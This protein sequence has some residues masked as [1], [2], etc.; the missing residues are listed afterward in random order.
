MDATTLSTEHS[1]QSFEDA[2]NELETLVDILEQGE[3]SLEDSLKTFERGVRLTR[4]CQE[5]LK[6]AEQ[7][8]QQ[9]AALDE[10]ADLEPYHRDD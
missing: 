4:G 9:L 3:M 6:D 8:V 7:K 10:D 1:I 5:A 2:L